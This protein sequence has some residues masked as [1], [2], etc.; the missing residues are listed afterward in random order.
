MVELL[1]LLLLCSGRSCYNAVLRLQHLVHLHIFKRRI[2]RHR[3]VEVE[4]FWRTQT[5]KL[6]LELLVFYWSLHSHEHGDSSTAATTWGG[7]CVH[8]TVHSM[9]FMHSSQPDRESSFDQK[10][11]FCPPGCLSRLL[12]YTPW[13]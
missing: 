1:L 3:Y 4:R 11:C 13:F 7:R 9:G 5:D 8:K 6:F 10:N 12:Y 2:Q